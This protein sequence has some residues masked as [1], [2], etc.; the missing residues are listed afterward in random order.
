MKT[1]NDGLFIPYG[2]WLIVWVFFAS[3]GVLHLIHTFPTLA[4]R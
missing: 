3:L 1:S 2:P 4:F